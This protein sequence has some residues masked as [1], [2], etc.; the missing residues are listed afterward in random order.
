VL[1]LEPK[2]Q[3]LEQLNKEGAEAAARALLKPV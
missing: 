3:N 1:G 2:G